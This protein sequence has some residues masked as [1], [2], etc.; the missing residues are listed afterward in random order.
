MQFIESLN[1]SLMSGPVNELQELQGFVWN[2]CFIRGRAISLLQHEFE[3]GCIPHTG[4]V[5]GDDVMTAN[6][7]CKIK[8]QLVEL[9]FV[10]LPFI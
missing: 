2:S 5:R 10:H 7:S 9:A 4:R 8:I 6:S 3:S 1:I